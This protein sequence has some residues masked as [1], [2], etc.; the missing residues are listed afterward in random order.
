MPKY[1]VEVTQTLR[2][3]VSGVKAPSEKAARA[4][5]ERAAEMGWDDVIDTGWEVTGA[6]PVVPSGG[7]VRC[8]GPVRQGRIV[9]G[10]V[11]VGPAD[12]EPPLV[13]V[14]APSVAP[15]RLAIAGCAHARTL[16]C[17]AP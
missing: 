2:G 4:K 3:W 6:R 11:I 9:G 16:L 5:V 14:R 13:R 15:P 12:G 8:G 7:T 1:D 10:G 17:Y